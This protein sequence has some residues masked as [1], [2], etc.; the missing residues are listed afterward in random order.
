[1]KTF[2]K[3][4]SIPVL[5]ASIFSPSALMA[6]EEVKKENTENIREGSYLDIGIGLGYQSDPFI[7]DNENDSAVD[8]FMNARFQKYGL[9]IEFPQGTS[10]QQNTVLSLGYNFLNTE[11]WSY[12]LRLAMNHRD[13]HYKLPKSNLVNRRVSHSKLGLRILGDFD[14]THLKFIVAGASGDPESGLYFSAWLSQ[15]YQY[16][17]WNFYSTGGIEYRNEDVVNYFYGISEGEFIQSNEVAGLPNYQGKSGF[18]YTGQVGFDYPI[19]TNW[20]FEGFARITLLPSGITDS[21]LVDGN[22]ISEAA[23]LVKYVF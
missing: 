14:K 18:E 3:L 12:D 17:N 4:L 22:T 16:N 21:P 9:F 15:N 11:H 19:T 8:I 7:F 2:T 5:I 23:I 13:L 6:A 10:K 1:M 20:V